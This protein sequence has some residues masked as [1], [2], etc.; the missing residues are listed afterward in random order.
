MEISR[1]GHTLVHLDVHRTP[2]D[3]V[4][5]SFLEDD[6]LI[7]WTATSLLA[8]EVD[9]SPRRGNDGTLITD[10]ILIEQGGGGIS[11][12][13]DAV[14]VETSMREVLQLTANNC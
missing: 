14:H 1:I 10:G 3:I 6:T 13:L 12:D 5:A 9:Q 4:L 11:F 2:P 7:L 8:R